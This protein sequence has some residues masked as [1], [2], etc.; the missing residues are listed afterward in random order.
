MD[1][2]VVPNK[3][4]KTQNITV[5]KF[6]GTSVGSGEKI[7]H[8]ADIISLVAKEQK[9][10]IVVSAMQGVTDALI[11]IFRN[12]ENGKYS[13][14]TISLKTLFE[15]HINA[16]DM[17]CLQETN[18]NITLK[19]F[20]SLFERL[21]RFLLLDKK[22][23]PEDYDFVVSFG[24]RF[25]SCLLAAALQNK[26]F[27]SHAVD[28]SRIIVVTE[29]YN[30]AK[31]LFSHTKRKVKKHL[32]PLLEKNIVPVVTGFFGMTLSGKIAIL[33]RGG[34]DYTATILA[35]SVNAKEVILWKEVNGV[36]S[37]D[38]KKHK[39]VTFFHELTYER[40]L[41]LAQNGA[42]ILHPEAMKPVSKKAI[43][44]LVKN[45]FNPE[46]SGTKIW[47]GAL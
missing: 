41:A 5:M 23:G 17:L 47:K 8:V 9:S 38:P 39:D 33:G 34:S 16:L 40:A 25:S 3:Q 13:S 29:E 43:P 22:Y 44:V 15:K 30:N 26:S 4:N 20:H 2:L 37:A 14:A 46:F 36:F 32:L 11:E 42:K 18:H 35:H 1:Y 31:P 12:C 24:E 6:G 19:L 45:T 21:N 27:K 10:I 7:L 28:S